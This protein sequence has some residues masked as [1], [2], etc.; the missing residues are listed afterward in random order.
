MLGA[1]A[2]ICDNEEKVNTNTGKLTSGLHI[3]ESLI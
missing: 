3:I 2:A 1:V